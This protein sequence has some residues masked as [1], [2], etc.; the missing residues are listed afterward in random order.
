MSEEILNCICG[1]PGEYKV[2]A[3]KTRLERD[4]ELRGVVCDKCYRRMLK[5]GKDFAGLTEERLDKE[6]EH[7]K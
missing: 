2:Y 1:K 7:G 4:Q 6:N 5:V 3:V